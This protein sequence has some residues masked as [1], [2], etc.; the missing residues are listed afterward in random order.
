MGHAGQPAPWRTA[1]VA[2][3]ARVAHNPPFMRA[4]IAAL[5]AL[6][7]LPA[8]AAGSRV[9]LVSPAAGTTLEGGATAVVAWE[10]T[11]GSRAEEWEAFLSLD[12]GRYYAV[13]IT[14]HLDAK[15]RSFR[16]TVPKVASRDVRIL[17]RAGDERD[18]EAIAIP[19]AFSIRAGRVS[20]TD[21]AALTGTARS[22][23][24]GA[25]AALPGDAPVAAWVSGDR[26]GRTLTNRV[27]HDA[28]SI[29]ACA[30]GTAND[31]SFTAA[32][33]PQ[34][35]GAPRLRCSPASHQSPHE[36]QPITSSFARNLL[37]QTS[38]LNI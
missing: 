8:L 36:R 35:I 14:P 20:L 30:C 3:V 7:A 21:A 38:R 10:G 13:R 32:G 9:T 24:H 37:L 23:A 18:E 25:E 1:P 6:L 16:F 12:G 2:L 22:D 15:I 17:L 28:A 19:G 5:V 27:R 4:C 33:G 29:V 34:P 26:Q 11:L 31:T